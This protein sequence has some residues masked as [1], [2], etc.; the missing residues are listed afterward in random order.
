MMSYVIV[1]IG[2][3]FVLLSK[4]A[5]ADVEG[6]VAAFFQGDYE[7]A[8]S[9]LQPYARQGDPEA[10]FFIGRMYANGTPVPQSDPEAVRWYLLSAEQGY[11]LAQD[12]LGSMYFNGYGIPQNYQEAATWWRK[13]AAQGHANAQTKLG[14]MYHKGTGVEEGR[15][16]S[17][18]SQ[19]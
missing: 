13:A 16:G 9:E 15:V 11:T 17:G 10:Q 14:N 1:I 5:L 3:V 19:V 12:S 18:Y 6:G 7:A 2:T 8:Y 4:P